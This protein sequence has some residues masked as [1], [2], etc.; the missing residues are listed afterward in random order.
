MN[1]IFLLGISVPALAVVTQIALT[2][3]PALYVF[4]V[5][6]AFFALVCYVVPCT[7]G[8]MDWSEPLEIMRWRGRP[9]ADL[10]G[11]NFDKVKIGR[12]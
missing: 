3:G 5:A 12:E 4:A 2:F 8:I 11:A 1:E 9:P 7:F 6:I 10:G